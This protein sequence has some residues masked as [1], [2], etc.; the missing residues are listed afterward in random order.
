MWTNRCK[1]VTRSPDPCRHLVH[2]KTVKLWFALLLPVIAHATC[3]VAVW[4]PN[5]IVLGADSMERVIN[6]DNNGPVVNQCKI[7]QDG[8]YF[9]VVSGITLHRRTGFDAFA[10]LAAS[11]QK[12]GSISEA[13]DLAMNELERG[14]LKV[15]IAARQDTDPGYLANLEVNSPTFAI[16]GFEGGR[17]YLLYCSFDKVGGQ[18]AWSRAYYPNTDGGSIAYAY[19]CGRRGIDTYKHAHPNWLRED[20]AKT[21]AGMIG[22]QSRASPDKVGGPTAV[23][24]L[25]RTGAHWRS[26][27]VCGADGR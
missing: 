2:S 19:L 25:D 26:G 22:M 12:S 16:A 27:G 5:K 17:A 1:E 7:Q 24:V 6:P 13:A 9:V 3:A 10:I 8:N 14:F 18:W 23:L 15:L 20:P 21:V 4:T 11:I